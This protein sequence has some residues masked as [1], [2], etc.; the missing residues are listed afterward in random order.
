MPSRTVESA[1]DNE[2]LTDYAT[3][4]VP[5]Q[6]TWPDHGR[7]HLLVREDGRPFSAHGTAEAADALAEVVLSGHGFKLTRTELAVA[8]ARQ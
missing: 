6:G 1:R 2:P 5:V 4:S 7:V 8:E 3:R